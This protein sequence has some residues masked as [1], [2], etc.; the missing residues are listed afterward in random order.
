MMRTTYTETRKHGNTEI[1]F[2]LPNKS[3]VIP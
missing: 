3:S 1:N 2:G